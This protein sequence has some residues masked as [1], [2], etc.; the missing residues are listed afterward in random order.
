M[1][2]SGSVFLHQNQEWVEKVEAVQIFH[3]TFLVYDV[4]LVL[5]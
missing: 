4:R 2:G 1:K 5:A 3:D